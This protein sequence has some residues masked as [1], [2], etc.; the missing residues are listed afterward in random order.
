MN[1]MFETD[2]HNGEI[3]CIILSDFQVF[4]NPVYLSNINIEFANGVMSGRSINEEEIG[5]ATLS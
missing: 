4:D 5:S 3:G 2:T 1:D